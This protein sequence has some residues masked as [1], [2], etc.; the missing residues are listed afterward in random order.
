MET[1][2]T[3]TQIIENAAGSHPE[4]EAFRCGTTSLSYD[5][6]DI[7]TNQL[8]EHLII[9]GVVKGDRVGIYMDRCIETAIAIY[10]IMKSGAA[11]VPLDPTAP[12][13]RTRFLIKDCDI[14]FIITTDKQKKRILKILE[15]EIQL[16]EIIGITES[17]PIQNRSWSEIFETQLKN[18]KKPVL[19]PEN[20]AYVMYTSG[21]TGAP[22]GIM[23]SHS[24]GLAYAKHSAALYGLTYQDRVANHAPLHFDI[25]TFGYLSSP[26]ACATTVIV[27]DAY[28]KMPASLAALIADEKINIF[29][30]VPLALSQLWLS[31]VLKN[32]DYSALRWVLFGGENFPIKYTKALMQSWPNT[33]FSNVYGPA[34]V[35]QCTYYHFEANATIENYIPIGKV[36]ENTTHKI[37]DEKDHEVLQG[38]TGE[39]V[40]RTDTMMLG[41]WNNK[42]LT[43]DSF[44][45]GGNSPNSEKPYY[46]TGDLARQDENG[47]LVFMGRNDRQIKLRGYRIELDEIEAV[48]LN[49]AAVKEA[50][51]CV[52]GGDKDEK[53]L[54]AAV[55]LV[56]EKQITQKE[57][58]AHCISILPSYAVPAKIDILEDF[59]R[60]GSGKIDLVQIKE[61][62]IA[63]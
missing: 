40:I 48:L 60:T 37:L 59:P 24:S 2:Q 57:L 38:E 63:L 8:A 5:E 49:I 9:S 27:T 13:L 47:D 1:I 51:V 34:E 45:Y 16:K 4:R 39:L 14:K 53:I 11:Y 61:T 20:L 52:L 41:Y 15:E 31:G 22:K 62:L 42:K 18:I 46:R 30:S 50:A 17:M 58:R 44:Y 43:Q 56:T 3:L 19:L 23:H 33:R 21:S 28:T 55:L 25:S 35:N 7:K 54:T 32:Y 12:H 10:G 26:L 29:Y 6:L 36:W